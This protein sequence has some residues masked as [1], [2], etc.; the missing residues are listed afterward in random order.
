MVSS[1]SAPGPA[2]AGPFSYTPSTSA[3]GPAPGAVAASGGR[4]AA[5]GPAAR[6]SCRPAARTSWG[7]VA[8]TEPGPAARP[9][10][11]P[12]SAGPKLADPVPGPALTEPFSYAPSTAAPGPPA[13]SGARPVPGPGPAPG[14]VARSAYRTSGLGCP[15]PRLSGE[16]R[17]MTQLGTCHIVGFSSL[18]C[19][20][21]ASQCSL[22]CRARL[23]F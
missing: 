9:S 11:E 4:P 15:M 19:R 16:K 5:P 13:A 17:A 1:T 21:R 18:F 2:P 10:S 22:S 6:P 20:S 3:P 7:P 23:R 14:P 12:G 8:G